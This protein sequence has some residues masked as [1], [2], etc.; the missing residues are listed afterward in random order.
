MIQKFLN[1]QTKSISW[2]SLILMGSY[3]ASAALGLLRDRLLAGKFGAGSELDSYYAAFVVPDFIALILIFGAISAALIPIF[4]YYLVKSKEEAWHYLSAFLNVFLLLLIFIC[5]ILI[6]F[7]PYFV[8]LIAPGFSEGKKETT[9]VLMRIMFLSPILLGASNIM[10]G[11]LQVF[12]RFLATALAPVMYNAGIIFGILFLT[13]YFGIQGLAWGVVLGGAMHFLIQVPAFFNS[14][15]KIYDLQ[16]KI[17]N[18][19]HPGV[20]KTL[21]LMA[22]RSLGLGAG[23]FNTIVITAIASTLSAGSIAVFNLANNFS[24]I[25]ANAMSVSLS[26]ALFPKMTL[27]YLKENKKEFES[28]FSTA[29]AQIIFLTVPLSIILFMLRAQIVR[30]VLGWGKFSWL[31]TRLT[32]AC[33]GIFSI[34]LFAQGLIFILSKTFY[35]AHNT[36]TPAVISTATVLLNI[37]MSFLFVWVLKSPGFFRGALENILKLQGIDDISVVGLALAYSIT[38][39][40]EVILLSFFIH[41]NLRMFHFKK[42]AGSLAKA[43][44]AGFFMIVVIFFAKQEVA[45]YPQVDMQTFFGVFLQLAISGLLGV[46]AYILISYIIKSEELKKITTAFFNGS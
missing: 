25:M 4:N 16:F 2:A 32:A 33:L 46:G 18:F 44:I 22:P 7:A 39:I 27:A 40:L 11:I 38:I 5:L 8:S 45:A 9:A 41:K 21:K 43:L 19:K 23:Q 34:G 36:K 17:K 42:L 6:V 3:L 35:A 15:F 26:T 37:A 10:T 1:T 30:I 12:H 13:P 28:K 31:D 14:G 24:S 29:F 20:L